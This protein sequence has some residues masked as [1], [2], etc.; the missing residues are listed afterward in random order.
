MLNIMYKQLIKNFIELFE[1]NKILILILS[2]IF[3]SGVF[4]GFILP[5]E[6]KF[7]ILKIALDKFEGFSDKNQLQNL[8]GIFSNNSLV[9]LMMMM[10]GFTLFLPALIIFFNG[11]II[12][13]F[14]DLIVKLA[15]LNPKIV[16]GF[17]V[18]IL[19]HGI[20]EIPALIVCAALGI[21]IGIK[22]FFK[23]YM[24]KTK[25]REFIIKLF[26]IYILIL[27]PAFFLAA[28]IEVFITPLAS[29][30]SLSQLGF[31]HD[32]EISNLILN[33][34]E[35]SNIGIEVKELSPEEWAEKT[36]A[37]NKMDYIEI[38]SLL[39]NTF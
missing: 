28:F 17:V 35:L 39:Y 23:N 1:K 27:L 13:I 18:S 34:G 19:P 38:L 30:G 25:R 24:G 9:G 11:V 36:K 10:L 33:V 31:A 3:L 14:L 21:M 37:L 12:G 8:I 22:I 5:S 29:G 15:G 7:S 6:F 2:V 20:I 16:F 4:S 26:K 32:E